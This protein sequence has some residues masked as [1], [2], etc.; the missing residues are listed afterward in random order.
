[1]TRFYN[2]VLV[3]MHL[4]CLQMYS[5]KDACTVTINKPVNYMALAVMILMRGKD[6]TRAIG[7]ARPFQLP[8]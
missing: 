4:K 1:M 3:A 7:R 6:I 8:K 2:Y 5:G